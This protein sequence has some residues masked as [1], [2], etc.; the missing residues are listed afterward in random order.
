MGT[1]VSTAFINQLIIQAHGSLNLLSYPVKAQ[2]ATS[3]GLGQ[4][5]WFLEHFRSHFGRYLSKQSP[6]IV[7]VIVRKDDK[8]NNALRS[9]MCETWKTMAD[10]RISCSP[11]ISCRQRRGTIITDAWVREAHACAMELLYSGI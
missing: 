2:P 5:T 7:T 6:E 8:P 11:F 9:F 4:T 1:H 10:D 3:N